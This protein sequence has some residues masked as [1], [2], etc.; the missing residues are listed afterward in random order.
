MSEYNQSRGKSILRVLCESKIDGEK[1]GIYVCNSLDVGTCEVCVV[2]GVDE[3]V[4]QWLV[5]VVD[6]VQPLWRYDAVFVPS[7]IPSESL[8]TDLVWRAEDMTAKLR[9]AAVNVE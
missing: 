3:V 7:Q 9:F 6:D 5:H 2:W 8:Q 4:R 1:L